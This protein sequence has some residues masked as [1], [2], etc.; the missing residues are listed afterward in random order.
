MQKNL[1]E[2]VGAKPSA[3]RA[4]KTS[5]CEPCVI[6]KADAAT[7]SGVG[8]SEHGAPRAGPHGRLRAGAGSPRW[9]EPAFRHIFGRLQ[10]YI[11]CS[12]HEA[13]ERGDQVDGANDQPF[14][15]GKKLKS[16]RTDRGN[17][18]VNKALEN[19]FGGKETV[20]EK[21]APYMAKQNGSAERLNRQLE[22]KIRAMLE[23]SGLSKELWA[24]A[25]VTANH[26][27]NRTPMSA[28]PKTPREAFYGE[29]SKVG[30]IRAF[31]A[32]AYG[33]VPK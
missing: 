19:V 31:G 11:G 7:L 2:G 23:D 12:S 8:I 28:H 15:L 21:T 25:V 6:R 5:V 32:R 4:L 27:W 20:H 30:H 18:Y 3:F 29:K 10:Q 14:Q 1:V 22:E 33:N 26:T 16:V 9:R 24:E 17:E 13:E